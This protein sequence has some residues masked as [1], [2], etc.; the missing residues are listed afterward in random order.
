MMTHLSDAAVVGLWKVIGDT[1]AKE[2]DGRFGLNHEERVA[3]TE[4]FGRLAQKVK[5]EAERREV[6]RLIGY[7]SREEH[8]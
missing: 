1:T 6:A 4:L 8:G 7:E 5:P 2:L 3:V